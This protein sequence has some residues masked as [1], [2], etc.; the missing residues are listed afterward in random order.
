MILDMKDGMAACNPRIG[1]QRIQHY[2][3]AK[4]GYIM[5]LLTKIEIT[6]WTEF[7]QQQVEEI[8]QVKVML[9][10]SVANINDGTGFKDDSSNKQ[11]SYRNKKKKVEYWG[12]HIETIKEQQV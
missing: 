6:R 4:L 10:I 1:K 7:L 3:I 8:L 12:I 2:N 11:T 9:A 5:C